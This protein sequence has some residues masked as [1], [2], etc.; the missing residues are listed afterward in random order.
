[1]RKFCRFLLL[2]CVFLNFEQKCNC[3][4]NASAES[5][6]Y[7]KVHSN[8][9]LYKNKEMN[10][11]FADIY[12]NIPESYFVLILETVSEGCYKVQYG[13]YVGYVKSDFVTIAKFTPIVKTLDGVVCDIKQ[14]VGTQIWSAPTTNSDV[15]TTISGGTKNIT[16]IAA[17]NGLVPSGGESNLWYYINYTPTENSTSVYEGYIYSESVSYLS[18]IYLNSETNPEIINSTDL[19]N[20]SLILISSTIRTVIVAIVAIPIIL[21][22][23]IILYKIIKKINKNTNKDNFYNVN[24]NED[25]TNLKVDI[26]KF[27]HSNFT[28]IKKC[29][30]LPKVPSYETDDELL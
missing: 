2:F 28:K 8:C 10:D 22:F 14:Y 24:I 30:S 4:E 20:E 6:Q 12:F 11:L 18:D 17:C 9:T 3:I 16:Y 1:M 21:V 19:E 25:S 13:K 29:E 27:K 15:L 5:G 23:V 7:A 26:E